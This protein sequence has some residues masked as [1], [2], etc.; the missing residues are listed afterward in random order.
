MVEG[1]A[2]TDHRG[3]A[4]QNVEPLVALVQSR[5]EPVEAVVVAHVERHQR[6]RAAGLAHRVVEL[7]EPADRARH[8]NHMG[9]GTRQR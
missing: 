6:R 1:R 7:L 3:I 8:R 4:D 9:A 5:S 2:L